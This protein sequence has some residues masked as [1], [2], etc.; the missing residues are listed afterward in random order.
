MMMTYFPIFQF[1]FL[2]HCSYRWFPWFLSPA[3]AR[4]LHSWNI[5]LQSI[6]DDYTSPSLPLPASTLLAGTMLL[7]I[8]TTLTLPSILA[9]LGFLAFFLDSLL[10]K[11]GPTGYPK[12]SVSNY[13]YSMCNNPQES[14]SHVVT[15]LTSKC[16][17]MSI[18]SQ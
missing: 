8:I 11:T 18:G 13:H 14:S 16:T 9:I 4:N 5:L 12:M 10:L 3:P 17:Q 6:T 7:R 2:S 15:F 1:F